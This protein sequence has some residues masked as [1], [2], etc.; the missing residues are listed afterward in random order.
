M[1][2][3]IQ[4]SPAEGDKTVAQLLQTHTGKS[5]LLLVFFHASWVQPCQWM[6]KE[7]FTRPEISLFFREHASLLEIDAAGY[8][9]N[10]EI[11][12]YQVSSLPTLLLFDA[13]G[14]LLARV[15]EAL[16]AGR[17]LAL[18][19]AWNKPENK[20]SGG[21]MIAGG[22]ARSTLQHLNRAPLIPA[23]KSKAPEDMSQFG[24]SL[25]FCQQYEEAL[26][27]TRQF[28]SKVDKHLSIVER[29]LSGEVS[30]YQVIVSRF[31][32]REEARAYLPH[33]RVL[34]LTGEII[35]L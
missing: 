12:A 26:R 17:L 23:A 4:S 15:E 33:L 19:Q 13:G 7:V 10:N 9:G 2:A 20:G 22:N 18:L 8:T 14:N 5:K 3:Q 25:R 1:P 32:T 31:S 29:R 6:R 30:Q 16:D 28:E 11:K 34:G 27:Y 21:G 35:R 24:I